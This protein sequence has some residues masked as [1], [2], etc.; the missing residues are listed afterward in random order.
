M[1]TASTPPL[2]T[3]TRTLSRLGWSLLLFYAMFIVSNLFVEMIF[4]LIPSVPVVRALYGLFSTAA[5]VAPFLLS[6]IIYYAF[7]KKET[8]KHEIFLAPPRYLK[9]RVFL[10]AY[11][12]LLILSGLAINLI[13]SEINYYFCLFIGYAP[14]FEEPVYYDTPAAAIL[15]LTTAFAPAFAEEYLFRGVVFGNLRPFG[16]GQAI[17]ISA[18]TFSL[19]HQNLGQM[20]YTFVC[21]IL[22]ALMY[23]WTGSIWCS[24]FFHLFNNELAVLTE[25]L[26]Y[27]AYGENAYAILLVWN[28]ILI[29][30]GLISAVILIVCAVKHKKKQASAAKASPGIFGVI[31]ATSD[32]SR[33]LAPEAWDTPISR[34]HAR[35]GLRAPGMLTFVIYSLVTIVLDYISA[36]LSV[37]G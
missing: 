5:Y 35:R 30:L 6:G 29:L 33:N 4:V 14:T 12:P 1:L 21:G 11:V 25:A 7:T 22:L 34:R 16:K 28:G 19:M 20:L 9:D 27:G 10:P 13:A 15:Y 3:Y 37:G 24:V 36:L 31:D 26:I 32:G 8:G 17:L 18:M 2:R 23:E